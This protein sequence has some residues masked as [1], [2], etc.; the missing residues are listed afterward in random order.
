MIDDMGG[1]C[2]DCWIKVDFNS[3]PACRICNY[4]FAFEA[5]NNSICGSCIKERPIYEKA[6]SVF[7]YN[8]HSKILLHRFK[9]SD[10]TYLAPYF[11]KWI[12]RAAKDALIDA[13][14][15]V[16][17]PLHTKRLFS[18]LYN[19]SSLLCMYLSKYTSIAFEPLVLQKDK[20]TIPQT[21]L[22]R[23]KRLNNVK[24]AFSINPE[25]QSAIEG[26]K[27]VL[28]DDVMTTGA[29]ISACTKELIKNG[30]AAKVTVVTL[31][32]TVI[33]N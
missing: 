6:Y 16:P 4:P 33:E 18:R 30:N 32:R 27:V 13:D 1:L 20:Y 15:L 7:R 9:Y 14:I 29:T 26:K 24:N 23:N 25:E 2:S 28:V 22:E 31:A 12:Q 8:E 17:V 19:Q 10:K 5:T 11:A 3:E 21:G